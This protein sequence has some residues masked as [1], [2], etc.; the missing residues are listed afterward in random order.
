MMLAAILAFPANRVFAQDP[1]N[2][3]DSQPPS[4]PMVLVENIEF[5]RVSGGENNVDVANFNFFP[6]GSSGAHLD[7]ATGKIEEEIG[8]PTTTNGLW[9]DVD[10]KVTV[11][12]NDIDTSTGLPRQPV[13]LAIDKDVRNFTRWHWT[14]FHMTL[15]M[16]T[17]TGF[18][19]SDEFDF[20][21][22]KDEPP[23]KETTGFFDDP[24][25]KDEPVAPDSLWWMGGN[26]VKPGEVAVF[27][28]GIQI[29]PD[30]FVDGMAQF[31]LREHASIPEP[32]TIYLLVSSSFALLFRRRR[33][34]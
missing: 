7:L 1:P 17:A 32:A 23:S 30:K 34:S 9:W 4:G 25:M 33:N 18:M 21:Y 31:V 8:D 24:P 28:L 15:G 3:I 6:V 29:P 10:F 11:S 22:F 19:E 26:G 16:R 14:D 27:W 13:M 5:L 20:L 2:E 12:P